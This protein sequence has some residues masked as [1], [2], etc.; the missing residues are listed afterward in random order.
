MFSFKNAIV[1]T[2]AL[3]TIQAAVYGLNLWLGNSGLIIG[4]F[5]ASLF[6]IHAAIAAIVVQGD[7][8]TAQATPLLIALMVGLCAHAMSK[9]INAGLT[10]GYKYALAFVPAQI[11]HMAILVILVWVSR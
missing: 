2:V 1:I 7:P 8:N 6:E 10:G 9:S 11:F 5:I 4:T 3:S